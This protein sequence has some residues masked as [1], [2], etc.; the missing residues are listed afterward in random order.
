MKRC[1]RCGIEKDFSGFYKNNS[2]PDKLN[3]V[4]RECEKSR[5]PLK[6]KP[7]KEVHISCMTCGVIFNDEIKHSCKGECKTCY[8]ITFYRNNKENIKR[9]F[10]LNQKYLNSQNYPK[11]R[12]EKLG[13]LKEFIVN[14]EKR[15][16]YIDSVDAYKMLDFFDIYY[17]GA[18]TKYD[19][20]EI[21]EQL[22][23]FWDFLSKIK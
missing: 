20:L 10:E 18:I 6:K 16:C 2:K 11:L 19:H 14:I 17:E 9:K 23:I 12:K 4:C 13:E 8:N 15:N 21:E 22:I 3:S 1:T 7:V 5:R